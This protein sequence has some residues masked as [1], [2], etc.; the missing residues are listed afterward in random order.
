MKKFITILLLL[1]ST[2]VIADCPEL[3]VNGKYPVLS[4]PEK[5]TLVLCRRLYVIQHNNVKKTAFWSAERID[6]KTVKL[7]APRINAFKVDPNLSKGISATPKDYAEPDFDAGHMAPVGDMHVDKIA[8]LESF[9]MS[10][11]VP[12][13]P[14]MNRGIWKSLES[15]VREYAVKYGELYVITGPVYTTSPV[16]TIGANQVA[17]PDFIFKVIYNP[18][19]NTVLSMFVPNSNLVVTAD[20]P[21]YASTLANVEA[22]SGIKFFPGLRKKPVDKDLFSF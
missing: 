7:D 17:V 19:D 2:A 18:K 13:Y 16:R 6:G 4:K 21:K 5:L 22:V 14:K 20:M 11:M 9:Y 10:N 1:I 8:M 15:K 12:Q 3:V